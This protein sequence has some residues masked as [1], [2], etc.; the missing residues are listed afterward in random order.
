MVTIS[1]AMGG[2]VE[3]RVAADPD[4]QIPLWECPCVECWALECLSVRE[5][6]DSSHP[7]DQCH[8]PTY[9]EWLEGFDL[10]AVHLL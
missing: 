10:D 2:R 8:V 9:A 1:E 4:D 5:A 7:D 3:C 6:N